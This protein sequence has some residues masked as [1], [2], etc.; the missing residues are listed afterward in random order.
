MWWHCAQTM[1]VIYIIRQLRN[2][3]PGVDICAPS[4]TNRLIAVLACSGRVLR[5]LE[6]CRVRQTVQLDSVPT[7][8]YVP[9]K[10]HGDLLLC[11]FADGK[12]T[13]I[14]INHF[15]MDGSLQTIARHS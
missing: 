1:Y 2:N 3:N 7:V 15:G 8:L 13:L 6:H 10:S 4:Q 12:V 14:R 5:L 9:D 11:G